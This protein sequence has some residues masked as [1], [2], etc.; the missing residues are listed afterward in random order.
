MMIGMGSDGRNY[1]ELEEALGLFAKYL[2]VYCYLNEGEQFSEILKQTIESSHNALKWQEFF[3]Y[4]DIIDSKVNDGKSLFYSLCF[5]FEEQPI[6]YFTNDLSFSIQKQYVCFE[7][8]KVKLSCVRQDNSIITDFHYDSNSFLKEDIERLSNQFH[9]LLES[10]INYPEAPIAKLEILS[11]RQREQLLIEFNQ[12]QINYPQDQL[13]YHLFETKAYSIPNDVAVVFEDQQITYREL[14]A[15]GNKVAHYLRRLG[16]GPEILVGLFVERSLELIIGLLGILKAGGA[17]LPLD[18]ALPKEGLAFRLEDAQARIVLTQQSLVDMLPEQKTLLVLLD[19]EW[20]AIATES[21]ENITS[22]VKPE[23]LAYVLFTSGSTGKPKG[24]AVE[25]QQ[26][27]NYV[28][29]IAQ[30][31]NLEVC[32]NFANVSTF[33]ADLGNTT[34]FPS[35]CTLVYYDI[36][37]IVALRSKR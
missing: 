12:T 22:D 20:E 28:N 5:D 17:Y 9:Q 30:K 36:P 33:A 16:V 34:I 1:A 11:D 37:S 31:L 10:V 23:N 15:K 21:G 24:V 3:R 8:F 32:R 25:H 35:L 29:A 6:N 2:P 14:N 18:P 4:E 26:L 19:T 7:P 27:F 13:I